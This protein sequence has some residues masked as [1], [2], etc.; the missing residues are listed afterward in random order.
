MARPSSDY[1]IGGIA[2]L[3]IST[4]LTESIRI[5]TITSS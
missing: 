5:V 3:V 2:I 4:A 1:S